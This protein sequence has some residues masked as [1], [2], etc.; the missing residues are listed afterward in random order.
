[1]IKYEDIIKQISNMEK[2]K[3]R[4]EERIKILSEENNSII[5]NLKILNQKKEILEKMDH[6]LEGLIPNKKKDVAN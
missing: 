6:D 4:N 1:M 2:K 3:S 5:S